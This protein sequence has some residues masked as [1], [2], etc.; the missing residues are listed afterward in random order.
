MEEKRCP[1]AIGEENIAYHDEEWGK[2]K[3]DDRLLFEMLILEGMQA[4]LSWV[5]IL[6]KRENFRKAFDNFEVE[7]VANYDE[8]KIQELLQNE[9][10]IRN[11]LKIRGAVKNA[12]AYVK[13]QQEFGTFDAYL[14]GFVDG[15]QIV[16]TY[17]KQDEIPAYTALSDRISKDLKKRGFT[18][19]GTTILY[20]YLQAVGVVNDHM[21]WCKE[22]HNCR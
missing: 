14:W 20:A 19:V 12:Q 13:I 6:K 3:H 11:R 5:T 4:G 21:T 16:N 10:I 8:D 1:W 7:R 15:K 18:F 17:E 22:Y 9:G 2:P